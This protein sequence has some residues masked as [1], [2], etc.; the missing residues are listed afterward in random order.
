[1]GLLISKAKTNKNPKFLAV[2]KP[3]KIIDFTYEPTTR[4]WDKNR[5]E[6]L[7]QLNIFEKNNFEVV[8]KLPYKFRYVF[9]DISGKESKMMN[10]DWEL[11]ALYWNCLKNHNG[12][13]IKACEDVRKKYLDDFAQTKDLYFFLGTTLV[14]HFVSHN[15]FMIIGTFHPPIDN[16][17]QLKFEF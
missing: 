14:N 15:P 16:K 5:L 6:A 13:E 9:T 17:K 10:E 12:N 4:E 2:F 3:T 8:K 1:M 11:G 7:K